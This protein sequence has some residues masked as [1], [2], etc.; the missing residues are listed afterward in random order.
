M[1]KHANKIIWRIILKNIVSAIL[2]KRTREEIK[3]NAIRKKSLNY[4][5]CSRI[6]I[7]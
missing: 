7:V 3:Y 1:T 4:W 2:R 5:K 6:I